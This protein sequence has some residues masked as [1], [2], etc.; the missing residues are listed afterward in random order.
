MNGPAMQR[1]IRGAVVAV[2]VL[3]NSC[4]VLTVDVDVYKGPLVNEENVQLT[5][6][7][8]LTTAAKPMLVQLRD[9]LEWPNSDGLPP[10]GATCL[11]EGKNWYQADYVR[12]PV[13]FVSKYKSG[14][15]TVI[16]AFK[17]GAVPCQMHFENSHARRVNEILYLYT[18]LVPG[19]AD[20]KKVTLSEERGLDKLVAEYYKLK[21]AAGLNKEG[22]ETKEDRAKLVKTRGELRDELLDGLIRFS[23]KV[24]FTANHEGLL[25][26][27]GTPGLIVGGAENFTRGLFGDLLTDYKFSPYRLFQL[28]ALDAKKSQY[29]RVLQAV[30]NSILFSVNELRARERHKLNGLKKVPAEVEAVN[31]TRTTNPK[32]VMDN[33]L[34]ELKAEQDFV[35]QKV[36]DAKIRKTILDKE[37]SDLIG[38]LLPALTA[39]QVTADGVVTRTQANLVNFQLATKTLKALHQILITEALGKKILKVW[40]AQVPSVSTIECFLKITSA[41]GAS[42][43]GQWTGVAPGGS[44]V[45]IEQGIQKEGTIN[46]PTLTKEQEQNFKD[47]I[48]Y[49]NAQEAFQSFSDYR[50]RKGHMSLKADDLL[51]DFSEH[52]LQL[53]Q[54][55]VSDE[56]GLISQVAQVHKTQTDYQK[57]TASANSRVETVKHELL[58]IEGI[59]AAHPI[60]SQKIRNVIQEI[61]NLKDSVRKQADAAGRFLSAKEIYDLLERL[62]KQEEGKA[63]VLS[64]KQKFIDAQTVLERQMPPF[65]MPTLEENKY[66]GPE[67]VMDE[68]IVLLRHRQ[69]EAVERFGKG[70][71]Q[72]KRATQALESAYQHRAGMIY[73]RPSSAYLRTSFPSTSLQD[74][75]NLTWDNMLLQQGIRSLPFSSELRDILDPSVRRDRLLTSELDKQYWQNINR[76]RISGVGLTNQVVA[77]DDVGNWYVKQYSGDPKDIIKSAKN[78]AL[79]NLGT[80]LPIDLAGELNAASK[81]KGDTKTEAAGESPPLNRV[82]EKHRNVY[83]AKT[84]EA[85]TKLEELHT[86]N[87]KN[88]VHDQI[89]KGWE[90]VEEMKSDTNSMDALK[91]ALDVEIREWDKAAEALKSKPDQDR[92]QAIVKDIRALSKF[93]KLLSV[94]IQEIDKE[95]E[96]KPRKK[97]KGLEKILDEK[98]EA[99]AHTPDDKK[100][101]DE[102]QEA[103]T[104]EVKRLSTLKTK[105]MAE[106]SRV[107]GPLVLDLLKDRKQALDSYEQAITFIGDASN[108]KN[109]P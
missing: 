66:Q 24:L 8:A 64:D 31:L 71:G 60:D 107:V 12:E 27:P 69:M 102:A 41:A 106:V 86:K 97:R 49:V 17:W 50:Q 65:S 68:V 25:S 84:A 96:S 85:S 54:K 63:T 45:G 95:P 57:E 55:R 78:L 91:A 5:Q 43:A 77:K 37:L 81:L 4:A 92:G 94:R 100:A 80:K 89:V 23:Q 30:G 47:A 109:S 90:N 53:E 98:K 38:T 56:Q 39:K 74:D 103:V 105:A 29:V 46:W 18:N 42:C 88:T 19:G 58:T 6:L 35:D 33:L 28:D 51:N 108:L 9:N 13:D 82:L 22:S 40:G 101:V 16:D 2:S 61:A 73:I 14:I 10:N 32:K 104:N 99:L 59:I 72:D 79:F 67:E 20:T 87:G 11:V 15:D 70:S 44:A 83:Q 34:E 21:E 62:L 36:S 76:V 26:P 52:V 3:L 48:A 75:P 7:L 93:E 1:G